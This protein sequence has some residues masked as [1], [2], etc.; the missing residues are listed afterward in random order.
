MIIKKRTYS[1]ITVIVLVLSL[2]VTTIDPINVECSVFMNNTA[3]CVGTD[4]GDFLVDTTA[5]AEN[6]A[7]HYSSMGLIS[8]TVTIPTRSKINGV[9]P[10]GNKNLASGIVF[11][12]GHANSS[13]MR[14]NYK[15]L[16]GSY[17][18]GIT[19]GS[20]YVDNSTGCKYYS[21][22]DYALSDTALYVFAGCDT[23]KGSGNLA[24]S[25]V[26]GGAKTSIGWT[27]E[28]F[29]LSHTKWLNKFNMSLEEGNTVEE[30]CI[31]ADSFTYLPFCN[32]KEYRCYGKTNKNPLDYIS[33]L[34]IASKKKDN[35]SHLAMS[36]LYLKN[37]ITNIREIIDNFLAK[38]EEKYHSSFITIESSNDIR[39]VWDV[40]LKYKG[41]YT[42][43]AYVFM[44][45]NGK[46]TIYDNTNNVEIDSLVDKIDAKSNLLDRKDMFDKRKQE[47]KERILSSL[48]NATVSLK[49]FCFYDIHNDTFDTYLCYTTQDSEG[50]KYSDCCNTN[51]IKTGVER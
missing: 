10:N 9:H 45:E 19:N 13:V 5:D 1:I 29:S 21:I 34:P 36:V 3:F 49:E 48:E 24:K 51:N 18:V 39:T 17:H 12:S 22:F 26:D 38:K 20:T 2:F 41:V 43:Y 47:T 40:Q 30:A 42:N 27:D 25:A 28:V 31:F 11:L 15:G 35:S 50:I 23:A 16:G 32:V 4:Y 46:L 37:D 14:F 33:V 44:Y 7:R 6:A 8:N